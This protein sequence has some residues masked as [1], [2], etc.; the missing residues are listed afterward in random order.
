MTQNRL[1]VRGTHVFRTSI[2]A[3]LAAGTL[4][5]SPSGPARGEDS[6]AVSD[7]APPIRGI[8]VEG[9][10]D[11]PGRVEALLDTVASGGARL[12]ASGDADRVGM[13]IGTLARLKRMLEIVGYSADVTVVREVDGVELR[14][15]LR[16][17]DRVRQIYVSGNQPFIAGPRQQDLIAK[18][19]IRPGQRLPP[20][21]LARDTF[22][23]SETDH[24]R[25][26]LHAQGYWEA[27]VHLELHDNGEVP[28]EIN[29]V[30]RVELGP[31]YPLGP[32][33][34]TGA[35]AIP[36]EGIADSFRHTYWPLTLAKPF[37]R[38]DLH[39]DIAALVDRYRKIGFPGVRIQEDFDPNTSVD[40]SAKNIRLGVDI[41]ERRHIE[42]AF[43]G[44]RSQSSGAL[45]ESLTLLSHGAYDDVEATA[46]AAALEQAYHERGHMLVK[47]QWRRERLSEDSDRIVFV[48]DE[49]PELKV[50][51]ISFV[52]NRA[53][54]SDALADVI[55]TREYPAL[56]FLGLGKGGYASLRQLELD[57]QSLG[58]HYAAVGYP[59]TKVRAEIAPRPGLWRPLTATIQGDEESLW[60]AADSLYVRFVIEESPLVWVAGMQFECVVPGEKLPRD[61]DFFLDSLRTTA[62][63][64]YQPALVRRDE[65]RIKRALG[66]EGYRYAQVEAISARHGE[67]M[68]ITW[69]IKLGPQ[70]RVGPIFLRGN[71]LT[72]DNTILTWA[73][74]RTGDILTVH[75][76]E[77]AQRNLALIQLFNNPNPISFPTAGTNDAIVPMLVE[78][79]ER[80]DH[81]GVLKV[82]GGGSTDQAPPGASF[83]ALG[84]YGTLGYEHRNLFGHGWTLTAL[85]ATGS[86]LTSATASFQNPRFF[87]SLFRLEANAGYLRQATVRLGDVHSGTGSIGFSREMYPGID[88]NLRYN[89]RNTSRTEMLVRDAQI[90]AF[91]NETTVRIGT[92]VS[93]LSA[94]VDWQRLD[95]PLIPS[96]GFKVSAGVE[97]ALPAFFFDVGQ[98]SFVK[99]FGRGFSVV[100]ILPWLSLHYT[101]RYDQGIPLGGAALLPKVERFPA[102]GDTTIRGYQLDY[103]LTETVRVQG[104]TGMTYVQYRPLGGNLRILQN[105]ELQFPIAPPLYGSVFLDSGVVGYGLNDIA[106]TDFRH[107]VGFSPVVIKLPVGDV[108]LSFAVPLN[109][110][111]GDDTWRV[112]FNVGLMF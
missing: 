89:L 50:R 60:R 91:Q 47:V 102:G 99:V 111:P 110:Q 56:G 94:G 17:F 43:E 42:V 48:V 80:H 63:G 86:S 61:D 41:R 2:L 52:G 25:D 100:P 8:V 22:I 72:T 70:V 20:S 95:H 24:V 78:V 40:S 107:G 33:K 71:F 32:L 27:R 103:A 83:P 49:G 7:A 5:L 51:G 1:K 9:S 67:Q 73:E 54:S 45:L 96:R 12:V 90:A 64:P 53:I 108:S 35:T 79:E 105:V 30:I 59:D 36:T 98:D 46:S 6:A 57:L 38:A 15:H 58:D 4:I 106:T 13:P 16:A 31:A 85:G 21:G 19:S 39:H 84:L 34:V 14:I 104:P 76:F 65:S 93:S 81:Y 66:D 11:S 87:G 10:I 75:G 88:A 62:G 26:F 77:R 92:F 112:H 109:R 69:R 28:A 74:L 37:R 68:D 3:T 29:L 23:A 18:L 97:V 101:F 82:G 44:N 55:R